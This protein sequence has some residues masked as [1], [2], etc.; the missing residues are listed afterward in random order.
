MAQ[1]DI[2]HSAEQAWL[3]DAT[4]SGY[5]IMHQAVLC[6]F[7]SRDMVIHEVCIML[8]LQQQLYACMITVRTDSINKTVVVCVHNLQPFGIALHY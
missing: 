4:R 8:L 1:N 5:A 2:G 7:V 3:Y 6:Y